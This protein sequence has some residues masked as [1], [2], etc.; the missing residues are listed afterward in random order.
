VANGS[1]ALF[2]H[3][4]ALLG[5]PPAERGAAL[6][7]LQVEA[8]TRRE[9][10][11]LLDAD[12]RSDT[13]I[14]RVL[15]GGAQRLSALP[16]GLRL[17]PW[18][19]LREIGA[20]GMGTVFL[21]E[22]VDGAFAQQVAIKV[23]RGF[24][25]EDGMRRLRQERNILAELDHPNIAR[26]LDGGETPEGQPFLVME[27]VDGVP[28][29]QWLAQSPT[30]VLPRLV[31]FD[32]LAAAVAHAHR[33]LVIHRDLKPGNVI[34]RADGEPKLLDFGVARLAA[35]ESGE[36]STRVATIGWASPE[37]A[38]GG[39]VTTASDVYSLGVILRVLLGGRD[40]RQAGAQVPLAD[41]ELRGVIAMATATDPFR[42]YP[43]VDAL[44]D[45]L[46][47]WR[48]RR[49]L[50]A[51]PDT[52]LYRTRKFV[53][54]HRA[55][56]LLGAM[57]AVAVTLF[58]FGLE[59]ALREAR[60]AR[61]AAQAAQRES[62]TQR[63]I[64]QRVGDFMTEM[65]AGANSADTGGKVLTARDVIG[66]A[67][68][69][70]L[71]DETL[72]RESRVTLLERLASTLV[73][74]RDPKGAL[75]LIERAQV[76]HEALAPARAARLDYTH[77]R[78][79]A[80][81]DRREEAESL[82]RRALQVLHDDPSDPALLTRVLQQSMWLANGARDY[83]RTLTLAPQALAA[84]ARSAK[85]EPLARATILNSRFIAEYAL[86]RNEEMLESLRAAWQDLRQAEGGA[87]FNR[88]QTGNNLAISLIDL[89]MLDE[90]GTVLDELEPFARRVFAT[91]SRTVLVRMLRM[92]AEWWLATGQP[93]R[94]LAVV[95][96]AEQIDR[97]LEPAQ[98]STD[99]LGVTRAFSLLALGQW[100]AA[101]DA[102]EQVAAG[103]LPAPEAGLDP[104]I[105]RAYLARAIAHCRL[106]Q[107]ALAVS[108]A[109]ASTTIVADLVPTQLERLVV[110]RWLR[111]LSGN[112][113]GP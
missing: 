24:P 106:G 40:D 52:A 58:V 98:R 85:E 2:E 59:R 107:P 99:T 80:R 90:A 28:L 86:G 26:L 57:A 34:V 83:E 68:E 35:L 9:L 44:R 55:G 17:G 100:Q 72:D 46:V 89:G 66:S 56:V 102:A 77:A 65:F 108:D 11:A 43:G 20:G 32:K 41:A 38:A 8:D 49:P 97:G 81:L 88:A 82:N 95:A 74:L 1:D 105:A 76:D 37:Q 15:E 3:F 104:M 92:R 14:D 73:G 7:A 62:E 71:R 36:G 39:A 6:A 91:D 79:L 96:E 93:E 53:A 19:V 101:I 25:T 48:E 69:K 64:A 112:C 87:A 4:E 51:L 23:L 75:A 113:R 21:G 84:W 33:Q 63:Q 67:S 110:E 5:L 29:A 31:L 22:R 27:Y 12:A 60:E 78:I 30:D 13:R 42:R 61:D 70:L 103:G 94:A 111:S 18:K 45:D 54:R 16:A 109:T 10:E 50:R 47:A